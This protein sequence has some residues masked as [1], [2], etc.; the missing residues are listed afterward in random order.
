MRIPVSCT[1]LVAAVTFAGSPMA[2]T[3]SPSPAPSTSPTTTPTTPPAYNTT[4]QSVQPPPPIYQPPE[5]VPPSTRNLPN[6]TQTSPPAQPQNQSPSQ[7]SEPSLP[8]QR[9]A[10]PPVTRNQPLA[11]P[12]QPAQPTEPRRT[13][14]ITTEQRTAPNSTTTTA[15]PPNEADRSAPPKLTGE[16]RQK[17]M[18][19]VRRLRLRAYQTA[20]V[21]LQ[22]GTRLPSNVPVQAMPAEVIALV[23]GYRRYAMVLIKDELVVVNPRT[24]I[25]VDVISD[26]AAPDRTTAT[27]SS[28]LKLSPAQRA[29][30]LRYA[31]WDDARSE[32]G[33]SLGLG[34]QVPSQV[35]LMP[36]APAVLA[37]IPALKDFSYVTT[38][39]ELLIVDTGHR[40]VA[41]SIR[42]P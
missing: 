38:G 8:S 22:H 12:N 34:A 11:E 28:E 1:A 15:A 21:T 13:E 40:N 19:S 36:F 30:V 14:G 32:A 9:Q 27:R 6:Q 41:M 17:V 5:T 29:T 24:H 26:S 25:I 42:K 3:T 39:S 33:L 2:Q 35:D 18:E 20:N 31:R 4:P 23:P 37:E 7:T 16:Q 10:E